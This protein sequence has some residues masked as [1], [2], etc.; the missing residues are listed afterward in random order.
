MPQGLLESQPTVL[1]TSRV[2]R[3]TVGNPNTRLKGE[4]PLEGAPLR[5][6]R[7]FAARIRLTCA[8]IGGPAERW[9]EPSVSE[10]GKVNSLGGSDEHINRRTGGGHY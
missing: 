7:R 10:R 3:A 9:D 5:M 1:R 6:R 4:R 2:G 8:S